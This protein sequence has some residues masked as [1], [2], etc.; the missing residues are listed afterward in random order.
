MNEPLNLTEIGIRYLS[1]YLLPIISDQSIYISELSCL[2]SRLGNLLLEKIIESKLI[3]P[4]DSTDYFLS[5]F[6]NTGQKTRLK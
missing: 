1:N 2:S 5:L 4:S 6:N 3:D